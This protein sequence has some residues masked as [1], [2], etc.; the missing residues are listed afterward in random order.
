MQIWNGKT[1]P[2]N[3]LAPAWDSDDGEVDVMTIA[4]KR[5]AWICD[6][7]ADALEGDNYEEWRDIRMMT[8]AAKQMLTSADRFDSDVYK[9]LDALN[10]IAFENSVECISRNR[11]EGA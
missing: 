2:P 1:T 5:I 8:F 10:N 11:Y 6:S 9:L 4:E 3:E 7:W